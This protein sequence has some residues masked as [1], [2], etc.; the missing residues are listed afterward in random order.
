M[1]L[2]INVYNSPWH[3]L[4]HLHWDLDNQAID[5]MSQYVDW[6]ANP[7]SMW[8]YGNV[9]EC[10][11]KWCVGKVVVLSLSIIRLAHTQ[12][13]VGWASEKNGSVWLHEDS[14]CLIGIQF[15]FVLCHPGLYVRGVCLRN[16]CVSILRDT[17]CVSVKMVIIA[18]PAPVA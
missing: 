7:V 6:T 3:G 4:C 17:C 13:E 18:T 8:I 11:W 2:R 16:G 14:L 5:Y 10:E 9:W 1:N 15:Q 12:I